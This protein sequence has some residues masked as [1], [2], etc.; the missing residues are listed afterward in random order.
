MKKYLKWIP[1]IGIFFI[2]N[3]EKMS[4]SKES[5]FIIRQLINPYCWYHAVCGTLILIMIFG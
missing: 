1:L 2:E 4:W 3:E 5:L